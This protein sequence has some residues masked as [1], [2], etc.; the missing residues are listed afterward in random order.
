MQTNLKYNGIHLRHI[1]EK[2]RKIASRAIQSNYLVWNPKK[3]L[4][5]CQN[6]KRF[7]EQFKSSREKHIISSK[8]S[9]FLTVLFEMIIISDV[10]DTGSVSAI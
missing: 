3:T 10:I 8:L 9:D 7:M 6:F 4:I 2:Y 5:F 1:L